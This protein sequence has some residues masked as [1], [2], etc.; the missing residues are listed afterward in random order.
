MPNWTTRA[1][2]ATGSPV[3]VAVTDG[4]RTGSDRT[5]V[6][7]QGFRSWVETFEMQR[8]QLMARTLHARLV[9]VE[10]PGFG[11]AGSRLSRRERLALLA[12]DFGP[13]AERMFDAAAAVLDDVHNRPLSFLGYSMGAS[14]AASMAAV[15][16]RRRLDVDA[17]VLVEPVAIHRWRLRE[18]VAATRREDRLIDAYVAANDH[19]AD[20]AAPWVDRPGVRPPTNRR[21]DLLLL[22]GALRHGGLGRDLRASDMRPRQVIVVRGDRSALSDAAYVPT[23]A[24]LRERGV[25]TAE[26]VV[27]GHHAFWHSLP[28]VGDMADR[29]RD[30]L[31]S[32]P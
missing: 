22:G 18:L 32:S 16:L 4:R 24:G 14:L 30:A 7:V 2:T 8:F 9:V 3:Q 23:L 12:G 13:L 25:E 17:V 15:G 28:A 27:S 5:F 26:V 20:A 19:V 11:V 6:V 29:L 21:V 10:V 1:V 31:D